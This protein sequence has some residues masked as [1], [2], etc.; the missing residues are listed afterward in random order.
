[1]PIGK[2]SFDQEKL[3]ENYRTIAEVVMKAKP[4]AAKG[5]MSRV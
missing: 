4:A 3:N 1:V 2:V 5:N